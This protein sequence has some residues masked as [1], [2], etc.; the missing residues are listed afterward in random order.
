MYSGSNILGRHPAALLP[1]NQT[2]RGML[3][4]RT[5]HIINIGR[6][7]GTFRRLTSHTFGFIRRWVRSNLINA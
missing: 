4:S 2:L 5:L 6:D 1:S 7:I 3:A